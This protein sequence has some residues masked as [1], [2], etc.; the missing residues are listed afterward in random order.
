MTDPSGKGIKEAEAE[1]QE[2]FAFSFSLLNVFLWKVIVLSWYG[3]IQKIHD[4]SFGLGLLMLIA[5]KD[6]P[7]SHVKAA[8][9]IIKQVIDKRWVV[10][11]TPSPGQSPVVALSKE[12]KIYF[13]IW[14]L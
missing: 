1:I 13:T 7:L 4:D 8:L 5:E 3:T 6:L 14:Q 11:S 2:V 9:T 12:T 10:Q